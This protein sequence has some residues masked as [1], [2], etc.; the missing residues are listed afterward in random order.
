M[1]VSFRKAVSRWLLTSN[2]QIPDGP[3]RGGVAGWLTDDGQPAFVYM[4]AT[5]YYLTSMAFHVVA[6]LGD[7]D[8]AARSAERAHST[9]Y[10]VVATRAAFH[11]RAGTFMVWTATGGATRRSLS[12]WR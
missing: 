6:R 3:E 7:E 1:S 10:G 11:R 12:I 5:G 4:E 8:A 2:I 9:G